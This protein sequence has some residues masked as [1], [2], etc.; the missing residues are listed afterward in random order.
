MPR[1]GWERSGWTAGAELTGLAEG[2]DGQPMEDRGP[3]STL[4]KAGDITMWSYKTDRLMILWGKYVEG[5]LKPS[6]M[7]YLGQSI[8]LDGGNVPASAASGLYVHMH[9]HMHARTA[10]AF[11]G[12]LNGKARVKAATGN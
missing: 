4:F 9:T 12:D 8:Q 11:S 2:V 6:G 5:V 3:R 7:V 10:P 1:A